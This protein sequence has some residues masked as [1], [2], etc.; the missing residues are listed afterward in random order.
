MNDWFKIKVDGKAIY[1]WHARRLQEVVFMHIPRFLFLGGS[2]YAIFCIN[3]R[4][5]ETQR[6]KSGV[7]SHRQEEINRQF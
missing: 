4:Q 3:M 7:T 2:I 5:M 6:Y 1:V